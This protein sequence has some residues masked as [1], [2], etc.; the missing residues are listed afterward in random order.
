MA[1]LGVPS[2]PGLR[3]AT[4]LFTSQRITQNSLVGFNQAILCISLC[5]NH[6]RGTGQTTDGAWR[7]PGSTDA[8]DYRLGFML[9]HSS[10]GGTMPRDTISSRILQ[11]CS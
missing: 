5:C 6:L 11:R 4:Q 2:P 9:F 8:G 1:F 3:R 10:T 7:M